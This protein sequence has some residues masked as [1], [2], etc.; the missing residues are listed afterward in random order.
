MSARDRRLFILAGLLGVGIL[1]LLVFS[2][3]LARQRIAEDRQMALLRANGAQ[4]QDSESSP[5]EGI[6]VQAFIDAI[7]H[8]QRAEDIYNSFSAKQRNDV[9]FEVFVEYLD[10]LRTYQHGPVQGVTPLPQRAVEAYE[11]RMLTV[12]LPEVGTTAKYYYL[13]EVTVPEDERLILRILSKDHEPLLDGHYMQSTLDLYQHAG[14]YFAALS[15]TNL[16]ALTQLV[17]SDVDEP[18]L[19]RRKAQETLAFYQ[20]YGFDASLQPNAL[21]IGADHLHFRMTSTYFLEDEDRIPGEPPARAQHD[22]VIARTEDG[23]IVKDLIPM[24][25]LLE[26]RYIRTSEPLDTGKERYELTELDSSELASQILL[27]PDLKTFGLDYDPIEVLP[28]R[29]EDDPQLFYLR[30]LDQDKTRLVLSY[31]SSQARSED[32]QASLIYLSLREDSPSWDFE[33][34]VEL[35]MSKVDLLDLYPFL[36]VYDY[37]AGL[38]DEL[39]L[40]MIFDARDQLQRIEFLAPEWLSLSSLLDHAKGTAFFR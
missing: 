36:D 5:K 33:A 21:E 34:E 1:F 22:L 17:Y 7:N 20:E 14:L 29:S 8:P 30:S 31:P 25:E 2:S 10:L 38:S 28:K 35:L 27:R 11:D 19:K 32:R 4:F 24:P 16:E 12:S 18:N 3:Y 9:S 6:F 23:S 15:E 40:R 26:L 37:R 39:G 13:D